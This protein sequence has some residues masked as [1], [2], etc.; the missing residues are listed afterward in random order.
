[1]HSADLQSGSTP[2]TSPTLRNVVRLPCGTVIS[3]VDLPKDWR[4]HWVAHDKWLVANAV[5][6]GIIA[7]DT[8]LARYLM[9]PEELDQWLRGVRLGTIRPKRYYRG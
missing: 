6:H 9:H 8:V 5:L 3:I 1:M 2:I 4:I 7:Y